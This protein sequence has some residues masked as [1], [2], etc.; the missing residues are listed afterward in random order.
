[1]PLKSADRKSSSL[2]LNSMLTK[3]PLAIK[4][5]CIYLQTIWIVQIQTIWISVLFTMMFLI[6]N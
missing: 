6:A 2:V 5:L 1:M 3:Q 4:F